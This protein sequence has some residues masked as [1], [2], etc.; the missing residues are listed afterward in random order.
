MTSD[1]AAKQFTFVLACRRRVL[2]DG[3]YVGE[4]RHGEVVGDRGTLVL[5]PA[6]VAARQYQ[7]H[8]L[9]VVRASQEQCRTQ[10]QDDAQ[11]GMKLSGTY[12]IG[13]NAGNDIS[14]PTSPHSS[15]MTL[16]E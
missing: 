9:P 5:A 1:V 4:V 13:A 2:D 14:C 10:M 16:L 15:H 6:V 7:V 3:R 11:N 8:L 12:G